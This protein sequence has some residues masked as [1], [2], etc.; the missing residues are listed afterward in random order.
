[1]IRSNVASSVATWNGTDTTTVKLP[2]NRLLI[3]VF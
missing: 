3:P 2:P 1:V